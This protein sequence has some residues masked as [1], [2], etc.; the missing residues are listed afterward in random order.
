MLN[1]SASSWKESY[2][3]ALKESDPA[4][5]HAAVLAAEEALF[6]RGQEINGSANHEAERKEIAAAAADLLAVKI[7]KLGWPKISV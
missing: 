6:L 1:F 3:A 7:H 5:L 2:A 4:K